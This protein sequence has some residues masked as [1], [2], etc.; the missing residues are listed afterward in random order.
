[1]ERYVL[2]K[3]KVTVEFAENGKKQK[4]GYQPG[5][6]VTGTVRANYFFGKP[7]DNAELS[8]KAS[9]MD[10][11]MFDVAWPMGRRTPRARIISTS[12]CQNTL[13]DGLSTTV[14]LAS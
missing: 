1:V 14:P 5:D 2:P 4:R 11:S 12:H 9:A 10:V 8:M 6:H 13:P 7:V 3:F